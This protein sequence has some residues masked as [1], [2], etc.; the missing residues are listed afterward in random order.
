MNRDC[1]PPYCNI[2]KTYSY[3][4]CNQHTNIMIN[5]NWSSPKTNIIAA[6]NCLH[7]ALASGQKARLIKLK[8]ENCAYPIKN[9]MNQDFRTYEF[10]NGTLQTR[11]EIANDNYKSDFEKYLSANYKTCYG[12]QAAMDRYYKDGLLSKDN[13]LGVGRSHLVKVED[14]IRFYVSTGNQKRAD[15]FKHYLETEPDNKHF[16][17]NFN[18][19]Q[20]DKTYTLKK[21]RHKLWVVELLDDDVKIKIPIIVKLLNVILYP[22]KFIPSKSI[23]KMNDY[24]CITYRIGAV[25][26]GFALEFHVPKKFSFK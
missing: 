1:T 4:N 23:L 6:M 2:I 18:L 8:N 22:I 20:N 16:Y 25:T 9:K 19:I 3:K 21:F 13:F 11:E 10:S 12:T 17:D 7:A 14:M 15:L 24:K 5:T 26:S